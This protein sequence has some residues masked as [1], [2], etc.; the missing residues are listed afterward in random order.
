MMFFL[1]TTKQLQSDG[2]IK[3]YKFLF[4]PFIYCDPQ[5]ITTLG[6]SKRHKDQKEE[7]SPDKWSKRAETRV[8]G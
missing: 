2:E 4:F 6:M 7:I 3:Q 8:I 1:S 5:G